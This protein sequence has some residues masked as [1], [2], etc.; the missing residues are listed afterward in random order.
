MILQIVPFPLSGSSHAYGLKDLNGY[1]CV[2]VVPSRD[3][4]A[5]EQMS[6]MRTLRSHSLPSKLLPDQM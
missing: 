6:E 5:R 2:F 1:K 4:D 3:G